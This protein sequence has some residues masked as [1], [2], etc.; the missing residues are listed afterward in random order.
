MKEIERR[1]G[2]PKSPAMVAA[3]IEA[4][5]NYRIKTGGFDS[6]AIL[7]DLRVRSERE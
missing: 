2:A 1:G 7:D 4:I 6:K 3:T 5:A